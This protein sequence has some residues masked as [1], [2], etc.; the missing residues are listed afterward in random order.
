M[1]GSGGQRPQTHLEKAGVLSQEIRRRAEKEGELVGVLVR[2]VKM[3]IVMCNTQLTFWHPKRGHD[4]FNQ[5]QHKESAA[6]HVGQEEHDANTAAKFWPQRSAD[7]IC[8]ELRCRELHT[9]FW[10]R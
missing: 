1:A 9:L 7:H 6:T 4:S 3:M 8:V 2:L 10:I 5:T